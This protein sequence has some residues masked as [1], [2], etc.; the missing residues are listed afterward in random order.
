MR[1]LLRPGSLS[2]GPACCACAGCCGGGECFNCADSDWAD[3]ESGDPVAVTL[4]DPPESC[5]WY[6]GEGQDSPEADGAGRIEVAGASGTASMIQLVTA[7][8]ACFATTTT[9]YTNGGGDQA[10]LAIATGAG[11]GIEDLGDGTAQVFWRD[12]AIVNGAIVPDPDLGILVGI[13]VCSGTITY[14]VDGVDV[15]DFP[16]ADFPDVVSNF[17]TY[18]GYAIGVIVIDGGQIGELDFSCGPTPPIEG[19]FL[20]LES[21]DFLL[22]ESGDRILLEA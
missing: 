4:A 10:F 8:T 9:L 7:G 12:P 1:G 16:V 20:L 3:F 17:D 14:S 13:E 19:D 22:L 11:V 18:G 5:I 21:G 15:A 6:F 2:P